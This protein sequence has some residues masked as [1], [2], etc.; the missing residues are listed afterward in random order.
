MNLPKSKYD[1]PPRQRRLAVHTWFMILFGIIFAMLFL[2]GC[3]NQQKGC[4][5]TRGMSG[6]GW[7]KCIETKKIF[8]LTP[9]GTIA[10]T[11]YDS[12]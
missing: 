1:Y 12:K 11:Y 7:I 4:K 9:D 6:Y 10:C 5:G 2:W 3:G 8:V